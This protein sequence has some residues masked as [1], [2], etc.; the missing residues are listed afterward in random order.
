M[1]AAATNPDR[2]RDSFIFA[3]QDVRWPYRAAEETRESEKLAKSE[4]SF[5][6]TVGI[7]VRNERYGTVLLNLRSDDAKNIRHIDPL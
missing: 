5:K 4:R 2:R 3:H 1:A 6:G 7:R